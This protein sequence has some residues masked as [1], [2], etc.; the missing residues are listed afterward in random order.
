M[1]LCKKTTETAPTLNQTL[2]APTGGRR[3]T[4]THRSKRPRDAHTEPDSI[5]EVDISPT[6]VF[7]NPFTFGLFDSNPSRR[8]EAVALH[9]RWIEAE[10]PLQAAEVRNFD[11]SCPWTHSPTQGIHAC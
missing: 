4:A 7:G 1:S 11:G 6:S 8:R 2:D 3:T 5:R 9:R 10:P